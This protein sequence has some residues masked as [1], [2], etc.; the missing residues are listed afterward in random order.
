MGDLPL[1]LRRKISPYSFHKGDSL[2]LEEDCDLGLAV[3]FYK[4]SGVTF[5]VKSVI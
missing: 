1:K 4:K 3:D 2:F 5:S